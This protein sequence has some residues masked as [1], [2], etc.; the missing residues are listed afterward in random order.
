M[1]AVSKMEDAV[2]SVEMLMVPSPACVMRDM[3]WMKMDSS[4]LVRTREIIRG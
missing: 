2:T 3:S 4:A 1:S